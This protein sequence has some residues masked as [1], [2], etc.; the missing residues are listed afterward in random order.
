MR[1]RS[2]R[3][4]RT[5]GAALGSLACC[6]SG[7][8]PR[9]GS[10]FGVLAII[11]R[12]AAK[13]LPAFAD[14]KNRAYGMYLVHYVFVVWLQYALLGAAVP[15][16]IKGAAVFVGTLLLSWAVIASLRC[17]PSVAQIIGADR[18]RGAAVSQPVLP[19][20]NAPMRSIARRASD[21]PFAPRRRAVLK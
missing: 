19:R 10:C 17:V 13:R 6:C 15:A 21:R 14:L 7:A 8:V 11:L 4:G 3:T 18:A 1:A 20:T 9:F 16:V 5:A 12:F 2:A